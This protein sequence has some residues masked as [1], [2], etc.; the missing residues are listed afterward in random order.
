M[1]ALGG[2]GTGLKGDWGV[3]GVVFFFFFNKALPPLSPCFSSE[4]LQLQGWRG[5]GS[6]GGW[7]GGIT[8]Q[9]QHRESPS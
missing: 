9:A 8:E 2:A 4:C 6:G 1:P 5:E 3:Y 7:R